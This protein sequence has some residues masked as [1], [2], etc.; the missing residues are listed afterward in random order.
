M[1][2]QLI[3]ILLFVFLFSIIIPLY[4][5]S[6]N[7]V[8]EKNNTK[9]YHKSNGSTRV[10]IP[11]FDSLFLSNKYKESIVFN[12]NI[13]NDTHSSLYKTNLGIYRIAACY[14]KINNIDSAYYY[15]NK[16]M[17]NSEDDR[18][19]LVDK[20]FDTLRFYVDRWNKVKRNI[21]NGFV[22]NIGVVKDTN[23]AIQLFYLGIED[24]K[25]RMILPILDQYDTTDQVKEDT[26]NFL[27]QRTCIYIIEN[28]GIPT[29]SMVGSFASGQFFFILQH[30]E[31]EVIE[32]YYSKIKKAWK[33]GD[34][35]AIDYA[36]LTDR[37]LMYK[38]KDQIYGTQIMMRTDHKKYPNKYILYP[39]KDFKNVNKRRKEMGFKET[40]EEW[41]KRRPDAFI[42]KEYYK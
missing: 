37:L 42:P 5:F 25:Y 16:Y 15:L 22:K 24:Q 39:V 40:V 2:K 17:I 36:M 23:L 18:A 34:F 20:N 31:L 19:I 10:F 21:E 14:S 29:I 32:K 8:K 7:G 41:I 27:M 13:V 12:Q 35:D 3:S 33:K 30:T 4:S 26:N 9:V 38:G 1:K 11:R 28:Y 6:Q